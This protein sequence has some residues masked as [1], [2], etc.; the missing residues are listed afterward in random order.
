M[1]YHNLIYNCSFKAAP[2]LGRG[3]HAHSSIVS[4]VQVFSLTSELP[5]N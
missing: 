3:K 2:T 5:L 4:Q 1:K